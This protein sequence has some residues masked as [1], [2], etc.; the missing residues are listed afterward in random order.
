MRYLEVSLI[1][2]HRVYPMRLPLPLPNINNRSRILP[3]LQIV[4]DIKID[5]L[6][7]RPTDR[8]NHPLD[9]LLLQMHRNESVIVLLI[10]MN[11]HLVTIPTGRDPN[12]RIQWHLAFDPVR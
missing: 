5:R 8:H 2:D 6:V 11:H 1:N 3:Q 7:N 4:I 12:D 10:N 9:V